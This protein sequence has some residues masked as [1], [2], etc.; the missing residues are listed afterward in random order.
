MGLERI[1]N[2]KEDVFCNGREWKERPVETTPLFYLGHHQNGIYRNTFNYVGK[3]KRSEDKLINYVGAGKGSFAVYPS[4]SRSFT[5]II[6]CSFI[7]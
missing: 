4:W 1:L 2:G 6:K 5:G 7:N 3:W